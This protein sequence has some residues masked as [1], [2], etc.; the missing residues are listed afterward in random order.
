VSP[1]EIKYF[2]N[3]NMNAYE[4]ISKK[5]DGKP[6]TSEDITFFINSYTLDEIPD[7][8]M[9]ALLMAIYLNGMNDLESQALMEAYLHSGQTINLNHIPGIKVDKHSTGGVGDKVSII[10]APIVASAG[11]NVPMISGRGLGHSGG[12]LDKLESIPG[13]K[14]DY[15]IDEF[16]EKLDQTGACLIGQT[17]ELAPADKKIYAL[18]DVTATVQSIPLIC[19]SI[20]SKKIA[21]GIDALVLDVKTGVG[22][23]MSEHDQAVQLAK[24]LIRIGEDAGKQTIAYITDMNNPLG[25][26][27]GNWLEI[28]EC[29]EGLQG[30]G[31]DDLMEVTYQLAGAMIYLGEKTESVDSGIELS[32]KL[33]Q[34]GKAWEKFLEI[35]R[36]QE[37][38]TDLLLNPDKYPHS[39]FQAEYIAPTS[40]WIKSINALEAGTIAVHLGAGRFKS[41]DKI[42]YKAGFRF[43]KKVGQEVLKGE[44]VFTIYTD[45]KEVLQDSLKRL[46]HALQI[47]PNPV[48]PPKMILEYLD[49]S[50]L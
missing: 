48:S 12:T 4:I 28:V 39:E 21:E 11:V 42:D 38:N 5:R 49:R 9:S 6:L 15:S 27:V 33:I 46:A 32:K 7:Y 24:S 29:I 31:P 1:R 10:L 3:S 41:E 16:K 14:V 45:K 8:Q 34:N 18:R 25:N 17:A 50:N 23:F 47:I 20:M 19:A 44:S 30:N 35:V 37:G 43:H 36:T 13:F 40:G 2:L 26:T 22:A